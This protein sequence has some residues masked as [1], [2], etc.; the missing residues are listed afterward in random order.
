MHNDFLSIFDAIEPLAKGKSSSM[1]KLAKKLVGKE[2]RHIS[3][4]C[5]HPSHA[6]PV[7]HL[8][9]TIE[10]NTHYLLGF[11]NPLFVAAPYHFQLIDPSLPIGV[12]TRLFKMIGNPSNPAL[13]PAGIQAGPEGE[14]KDTPKEAS[15]TVTFG[16]SSYQVTGTMVTCAATQAMYA[17]ELVCLSYMP[18]QKMMQAEAA[19]AE[20]VDTTPST[21]KALC[22]SEVSVF[23]DD[24]YPFVRNTFPGPGTCVPINT[25]SSETIYGIMTN[26]SVDFYNRAGEKAGLEVFGR[27]LT[28]LDLVA[29]GNSH[30][31]VL[32]NFA[33][34]HLSID[35]DLI[36]S[37]S[38]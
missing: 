6:E 12:A 34:K 28:E 5:G 4:T 27:R 30:P 29:G 2:V 26:K 9:G 11:A 3:F 23:V 17:P 18:S 10:G 37:F 35:V 1:K 19:A 16:A 14:T 24:V 36:K 15:A 32:V 7:V 38:E 8:L 22:A 31:S 20:V 33:E 25:E 13:W 21:I